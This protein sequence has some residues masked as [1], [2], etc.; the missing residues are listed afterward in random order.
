MTTALEKLLKYPP[1]DVF[2]K[3]PVSV[4]AFALD[5]AWR[6]ADGVL[7]AGGQTYRFDDFT[8]SGLR[9]ALVADGV[10][11]D[12][13]AA[14]IGHLSA[15]VLVEGSGV[16]GEPLTAFTSLLWVLLTGY[17]RELLD[18]R[19]AVR[20]GLLQLN[21]NTASDEW[22]DLYGALFGVG[23]RRA[24]ELDAAY[25]ARIKAEALR[26][27]VN[28]YGI[29]QAITDATGYRVAIEEPWEDLFVLDESELDGDHRMY[30][31]TTVGPHLIR[32]VGLMPGI[33]WELVLPVIE[34]NKAAG[35][36]VLPSLSRATIY[37]DTRSSGQ[38]V[39]VR[40]QSR[41]VSRGL[42]EDVA[43]LDVMELDS[44]QDIPVYSAL[45]KR[46][47]MHTS[48]SS[49]PVLTWGDLPGWTGGSWAGSAH[50][51]WDA[52][53][54]AS[55]QIQRVH[56]VYGDRQWTPQETWG[57]STWASGAPMVTVL[58]SS[59]NRQPTVAGT[60]NL[61]TNPLALDGGILVYTP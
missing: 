40:Q 42:Y 35:V 30:D 12:S 57:G 36:I 46:R 21:L 24:G 25:A 22:V 43:R 6:V 28:R 23:E 54:I 27:R 41:S 56:V 52:R 45:H 15:W 39:R 20:Q 2:D 32:P 58:H 14:D 9:A 34:R 4:R 37:V 18:L 5:V 26:L 33:K 44:D 48:G 60:I 50:Y 13:G 29:E 49:V 53:H 59:T 47:V 51:A 7:V 10:A 11:V 61:D 55:Y 1:R 16:A 3:R 8:V 19:E 17:A 38:G 31:G